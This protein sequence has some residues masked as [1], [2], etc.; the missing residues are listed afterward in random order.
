MDHAIKREQSTKKSRQRGQLILAMLQHSTIEKAAVA[1][2]I[3]LSTAWR[4]RRT[5]EFRKEYLE[6]RREAVFHGLERMQQGCG[7]AAS[8]LLK[9]MLDPASPA[10]SRVRAAASIIQHSQQLLEAE[11][12]ELRL[13]RLEQTAEDRATHAPE[14]KPS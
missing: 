2:G 4:I 5:P 1:I 12:F 6:A 7:A 10:N 3:S 11:D 14:D 13:Q 9:I 8:T